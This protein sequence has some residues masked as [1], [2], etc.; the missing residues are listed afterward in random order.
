MKILNVVVRISMVSMLM[1][2][3]GAVAAQQ[4]VY[5]SKPIRFIIPF[6]PGGSN[7]LIARLL[8]Q[9][10][11]ESWGQPVVVDNRPGG[12]TVIG[13]EALV[14]SPA[15]GYAILLAASSHV[16]TPLLQPTG[17]DP[18]KDFAPIATI[19][20]TEFVLAVHPSVPANT[21]REFIA[22]ARSR[23]GQLNYGSAGTG[24]STHL[25]GAFFDVL[26]GTRMQH[27][28]YKGSGP[29]LTDLIGGQI[30]LYFVSPGP[31]LPIIQSGKIRAIAISGEARSPALPQVPTFTEAGLPGFDVKVWYGLLAPAGTP[32]DIIDKF[33]SEIGKIA[34]MPDIREKL[35][36]QG[37]EPLYISTERFAALIKADSSKYA[38]IIKTANIKIED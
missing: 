8:G 30:Q 6:P 31:S 9:K 28:P 20:S 14:K 32:R 1:A 23:P 21:L 11:T 4:Q 13:T 22:L 18:I 24:N 17:Y 15:D 16:T 34:A 29:A 38:K 19:A 12:N 35:V 25:A 3:A 7:N 5:P 37:L 10:L 33:S 26:A 27:I 36:G 2:L